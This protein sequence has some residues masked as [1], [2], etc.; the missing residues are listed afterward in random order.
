M[1]SGGADGAVWGAGDAHVVRP[2]ECGRE[3]HSED[4]RRRRDKL[5]MKMLDHEG[6]M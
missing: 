1:S 6:Y 4:E 3:Q 2:K 5:A